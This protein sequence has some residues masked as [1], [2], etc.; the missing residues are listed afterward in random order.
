MNLYCLACE[1]PGH[2][3]TNCHATHA[4][5]TPRMREVFRLVMAAN[6][7]ELARS[8][9]ADRDPELVADLQRELLSLCPGTQKFN[10]NDGKT[11][12]ERMARIEVLRHQIKQIDPKAALYY[13]W[14]STKDRA[15]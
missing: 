2:A 12:A 10:P 9:A 6:Y 11:A 4:A 1:A 14:A 3:T 13:G 7:P 8:L 15:P 5:N